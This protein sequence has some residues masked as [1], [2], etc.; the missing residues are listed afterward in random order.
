MKPK[1]KEMALY[2]YENDLNE[3]P[4][5]DTIAKV[6]QE[7]GLT[8]TPNDLAYIVAALDTHAWLCGLKTKFDTEEET[9]ECQ[10]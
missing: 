9:N 7:Y 1:V 6:E 5:S 10:I 8:L 2:V 3:V 4:V